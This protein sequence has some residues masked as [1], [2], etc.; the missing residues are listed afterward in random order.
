MEYWVDFA[1]KSKAPVIPYNFIVETVCD[2]LAAGMVYSGK[3]WTNSTQYEYYTKHQR[4]KNLINPKSDKFI[5]EVLSGVKEN[6]IERTLTKKNL[7]ALY[8]KYCID[9]KTEYV[10]ESQKGV[11]KI[12]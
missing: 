7:K 5:L 4:E 6:G 1:T 9:D 12:V 3:N 10:Y 11:W 8:K 2:E